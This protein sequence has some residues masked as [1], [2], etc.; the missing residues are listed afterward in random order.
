[1]RT[2]SRI[3]TVMTEVRSRI[4]S[5]SYLP[6]TRLPSVRA[7]ALAMKLSISTVVE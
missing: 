1:M 7:Q 4:S 2:G 5:R 6:G 3:E